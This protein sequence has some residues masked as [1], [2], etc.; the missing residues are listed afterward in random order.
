MRNT[1]A[2][3]L[4]LITLCVPDILYAQ[5]N[6]SQQSGFLQIKRPENN[7]ALN[8]RQ[9]AVQIDSST[10]ELILIGGDSSVVALPPGKHTVFVH[11]M[12]PYDPNSA[13][14]SWVSERETI[15]IIASKVVAITI[16]PKT[17]QQS[18]CCG[19]RIVR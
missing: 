2:Q 6:E 5:A 8:I 15:D 14:Y 11:S 17:K 12:D 10:A 19:W 18:Y 13:D 7:G 9:C 4:L 16:E 3:I 1:I